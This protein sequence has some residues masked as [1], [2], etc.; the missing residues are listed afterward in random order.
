MLTDVLKEDAL[1]HKD[2][3]HLGG[4]QEQSE[5]LCSG[6]DI[7]LGLRYQKKYL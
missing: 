1:E 3:Q 6:E 2:R 7:V 4:R 5:L